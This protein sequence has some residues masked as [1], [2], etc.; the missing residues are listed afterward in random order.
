MNLVALGAGSAFPQN[1]QVQRRFMAQA[2][3][4]YIAWLKNI[5]LV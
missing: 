3:A 4:R 5:S 2:V 1:N